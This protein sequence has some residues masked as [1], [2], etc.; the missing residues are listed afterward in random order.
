MAFAGTPIALLFVEISI[1]KT[2]HAYFHLPNNA[3]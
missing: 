3:I 1:A 2:E